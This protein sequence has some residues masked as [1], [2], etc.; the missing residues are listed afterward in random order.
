MVSDVNVI[1]LESLNLGHYLKQ[2]HNCTTT[3]HCLKKNVEN[4]KLDLIKDKNVKIHAI[5]PDV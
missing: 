5:L 3:V 1:I 2:Q 4:R